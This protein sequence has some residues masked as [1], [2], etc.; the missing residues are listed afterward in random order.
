MSQQECLV[1]LVFL[2][3]VLPLDPYN[4]R[5]LE[6]RSCV[7]L[8]SHVSFLVQHCS[9]YVQLGAFDAYQTPCCDSP[10]GFDIELELLSIW[11][12]Q[13]MTCLQEN[14]AVRLVCLVR[15]G[16]SPSV[17]FHSVL[18]LLDFRPGIIFWNFLQAPLPRHP[19]AHHTHR[20][21]DSS[22]SA[23]VR[24][25]MSAKSPAGTSLVLGPRCQ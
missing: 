1:I 8:E 11:N 17:R 21:T 16:H 5:M 12:I 10:K 18:C 4:L 3:L 23:Q 25:A 22:E 20:G 6:P 9:K 24:N 2:N 19:Y 14:P 7:I 13:L 15:R